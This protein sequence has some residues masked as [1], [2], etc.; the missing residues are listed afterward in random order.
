MGGAALRALAANTHG[1]LVVVDLREESHGFLGDLP[2]SWYAP[3]NAGNRGRTREA[4]LAEESRLLDSLRRRES[5]AFD[6]QGKDR[7]PPEPE[8]PIA[9]F[10][11]ART[12]ESICTEA[13][14]GHAR[15]LVTDHHGPD[16]GEI[17]HFVALLER[18]PDGAWVHYHCRGGRGRTSTFLLLHDLL[19]NAGRLPFSVIAHRQRV[20]SEGYDLLAHGEPAD[21]KTPLRRA[22]AEI[23]RAFAEFV[24]E[25]AVGGNQRFTEW[26]GARQ[27]TR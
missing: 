23:V 20:L 13:G 27:E 18:L 2:V 25:R 4:T 24:R 19:R 10:G 14:A 8:R 11:T 12:E 21:W 5:L 26:L 15:L 17:D 7:G 3:R 16:A 22:R 6:G 9:A 1:P